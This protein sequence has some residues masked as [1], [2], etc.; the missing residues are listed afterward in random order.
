MHLPQSLFQSLLEL[1]VERF[2]VEPLLEPGQ[3]NLS[4]F[5]TL[6]SLLV[7]HRQHFQIHQPVELLQLGQLI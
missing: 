7:G 2:S 3:S 1:P 5:P 6:R 4:I